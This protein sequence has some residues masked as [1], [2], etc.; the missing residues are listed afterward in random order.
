MKWVDMINQDFTFFRDNGFDKK[1][2]ERVYVDLKITA[3]EGF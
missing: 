1:L 2:M 3:P